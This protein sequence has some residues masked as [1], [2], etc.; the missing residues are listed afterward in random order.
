LSLSPLARWVRTPSFMIA[1]WIPKRS[2]SAS[3]FARMTEAA[4]LVAAGI[5]VLLFAYYPCMQ[6][7]RVS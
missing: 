5:S 4:Y 3:I 1:S 2:L 7:S 6:L